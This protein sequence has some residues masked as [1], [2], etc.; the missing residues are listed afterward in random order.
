MMGI[1]ESQTKWLPQFGF[2]I[3]K[4]GLCKVGQ[5]LSLEWRILYE[6]KW[7]FMKNELKWDNQI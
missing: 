7:N 3:D 1:Y 6:Q 4:D 5:D 2:G